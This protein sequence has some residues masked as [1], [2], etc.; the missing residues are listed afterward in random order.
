MGDLQVMSASMDSD[1]DIAPFREDFVI[2]K[3]YVASLI[4]HI[5]G[6]AANNV[7]NAINRVER[8]VR[9]LGQ[10]AAAQG[11]RL[12]PAV[13]V[14]T[15]KQPLVAVI[16]AVGIGHVGARV[17][18][19]WVNSTTDRQDC[20]RQSGASPG[21]APSIEQFAPVAIHPLFTSSARNCAQKRVSESRGRKVWVD[22]VRP[23]RRSVNECGAGGEVIR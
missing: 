15:E 4:E 14:F 18:Q 12:A 5:K 6:G 19:W 13:R 2:L 9:S 8:H 16:I 1:P 11:E 17:L 10:E 20:S 3:R 7:Q 23:R 22:I 21:E